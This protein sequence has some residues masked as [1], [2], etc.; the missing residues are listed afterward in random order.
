MGKEMED[1]IGALR[2]ARE[3][4]LVGGGPDRAEKQHQKG[5]LTARERLDV[6]LDSGSFTEFNVLAGHAEGSPGD[7]IVAGHGRIDGRGVCVYSQDATVLGGSIGTLHGYRLYRTAEKALEMGVP[8]IGLHDSPGARAPREGTPGLEVGG[9]TGEKGGGSVFFPNT[10]ASGVVPQVA[11]IMGSCAG[12]SVYSP[13]LMDFIL[14]VDGTSHM[15]ITGP[16][17]VKSVTY[18]D[19]SMEEL[20]GAKVHCQVSGVADL[21]TKDDAECLGRIRKLLGFLPSNC[22]ELPPVADSGDD[23]ERLLDGIE[24]IV[25]DDSTKPYDMHRVIR[26][27]VDSEDFFEIKPEFAP[28]MIVGFGRLAGQPVGIVA[29]QPMCY[30]GALTARSSSKQARFIRTCDSFNVPLIVLVDTPAYAPG[31]EQEHSGIICHGAKVIYA[32]CEAVVPRIGVLLR[33]C[34]G[35]GGL[36]MGVV[37]GLGTDVILS[38][39]LVEFGVMGAKST[40][41]LFYEA[42]IAR[43]ADPERFIDDKVREYREQANVLLAASGSMQLEQDVVEPRETRRRLIQTLGLLRGKNQTRYLKKHGN[44]PL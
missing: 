34:F 33:K 25:P 1:M 39:P 7:G 8:L 29:N 2:Q 16:R 41:K 18:E 15:F 26:C 17:I 20:G 27:L 5:K 30:G 31:S 38:W 3:R 22:N 37:P 43:A 13:A 32:L 12:I 24:D 36:G 10:Q 44:I 21:R 6:L 14:M 42:E 23:P 11:A 35:G 19:V 40:V 9:A 4:A 28:E